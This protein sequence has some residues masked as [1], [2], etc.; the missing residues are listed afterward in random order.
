MERNGFFSQGW[1]SLGA[2]PWMTFEQ[3][4]AAN[5][6][7]WAGLAIGGIGLLFAAVN[8]LQHHFSLAGFN[9]IGVAAGVMG[10]F[11][12]AR[13][14]LSWAIGLLCGIGF[15]NCFLQAFLLRNGN[16][17]LL[18]VLLTITMYLTESPVRRRLAALLIGTAY[19]VVEAG[20]LDHF[21]PLGVTKT[22]FLVN[23]GVGLVSLYAYHEMIHTVTSQYRQ[24][25]ETK[26]RE[27]DEQSRL[28]QQE[29]SKLR[30]ANSA[31]ER[32]FSIL[33]HDLCAPVGNL[34]EALAYL[35]D[36]RLSPEQFRAMQRGFRE[37]VDHVHASL[38]GLLEWSAQQMDAIAPRFAA[39]DLGAVCGE[40]IGLLKPIAEKKAIALENRIAPGTLV[41]ADRDQVRAVFRNLFSNALKFTPSGGSVQAEAEAQALSASERETWRVTVRDTGI[42]IPEERARRLFDDL[43]H[44][45]TPGL[46]REKGLGL[47]LAICRD[48]IRAHH[49]TIRVESA[50]GRGTA[51][52]F[53]LPRAD[54]EAAVA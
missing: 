37:E 8:L 35:E 3:R 46:A 54:A 53:T 52:H 23:I 42:G 25:V 22:R 29:R 21:S 38:Q 20:H 49:G 6:L 48:F 5:F 31:K 15:V 1:T 9:L 4:I 13:G 33:S 45:S 43:H 24:T 16:E 19:L 32:L 44:E 17:I 47:G 2:R 36:G 39:V 18:L 51:I 50:P 40:A 11:S 14:R 30:E 27:L 28:L 7:S 34:K 12:V 26:N 41:R 10:I